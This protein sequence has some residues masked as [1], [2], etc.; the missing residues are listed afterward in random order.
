[1]IFLDAVKTENLDV[2]SSYVPIRKHAGAEIEGVFEV[3][4][5]VTPLL[6]KISTIQINIVIGVTL[7]LALL[8]GALFLLVRRS[9][10][11]IR[12]QFYEQKRAQAEIKE[13]HAQEEKINDFFHFT[14][15]N[16]IGYVE[17]GT[18]KR[19]LLADPKYNSKLVAQ[20][21]NGIMI[22]GKNN[23]EMLYLTK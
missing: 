19:E 10:A 1:M 8:Y 13:A 18:E 11:L 21:I 15:L 2:I 22:K 5:E 23:R 4:D 12:E 16:I 6:K 7:I 3:Y 20:F 17:R 9:D 14:L